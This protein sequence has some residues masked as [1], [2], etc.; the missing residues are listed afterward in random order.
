MSKGCQLAA[1]T[2]LTSTK[3]SQKRLFSPDGSGIPDRRK[4]YSEQQEQGL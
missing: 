2:I 1:L 4:G 3:E